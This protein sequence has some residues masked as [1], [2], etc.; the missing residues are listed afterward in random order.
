M[1]QLAASQYILHEKHT[2]GHFRHHFAVLVITKPS[3]LSVFGFGAGVTCKMCGYIQIV[4]S[5][6]VECDC[7][8]LLNSKRQ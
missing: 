7:F 4:I 1:A 2:L 8:I 6:F 5:D 3:F